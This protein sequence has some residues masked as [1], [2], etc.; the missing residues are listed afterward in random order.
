MANCH[1]HWLED[2][3][4]KMICHWHNCIRRSG[5][6][7][8]RLLFTLHSSRDGKVILKTQKF[9]VAAHSG[10]GR[11]KEGETDFGES[12]V[13]QSRIKIHLNKNR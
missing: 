8:L 4:Q 7:I 1:Q 6:A 5:L 2:K 12:R 3:G 13:K 10:N 11:L 9:I